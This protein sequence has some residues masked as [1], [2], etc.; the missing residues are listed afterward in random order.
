[1]KK[2]DRQE[3][4]NV[5]RLLPV[6]LHDKAANS[7]EKKKCHFLRKEIERFYLTA[8]KFLTIIIV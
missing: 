3:N 6:F 7:P 2:I 8:K 4:G 5:I 1:M